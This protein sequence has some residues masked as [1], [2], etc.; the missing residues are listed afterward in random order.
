MSAA[1]HITGALH[2]TPANGL[3]AMINWLPTVL[4][5]KWTAMFA[6]SRWRVIP[7]VHHPFLG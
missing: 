2:T 4:L 6:L 3:V 5:A 7:S 1:I